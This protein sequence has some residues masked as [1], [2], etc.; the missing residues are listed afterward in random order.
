MRGASVTNPVTN[1][2][3]GSETAQIDLDAPSV[4]RPA[5]ASLGCTPPRRIQ[6]TDPCGP[7]AALRLDAALS[8]M[9][10][11]TQFSGWWL[12]VIALVGGLLA[13]AVVGLSFV[14]LHSNWKQLAWVTPDAESTVP[15]WTFEGLIPIV[16]SVGWTG[17]ILHARSHRR[18][19]GL[20]LAVAAIELALLAFA[21]LPVARAGNGGVWASSFGLPALALALFGGPI[22]AVIWPTTSRVVN[23]WQ[24]V[25]A[26]LV[27]A[28]GVYG[29][30]N[31]VGGRL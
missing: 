31:S 7:E 8:D 2:R 29:S 23:V 6:P 4:R 12:P 17:L 15:F 21:L 1:G 10:P 30:F 28:V 9:T 13:G 26:G 18:W 20:S 27:L 16:I 14:A 25:V 19:L 5:N 11:K 22:A 3:R 24:H